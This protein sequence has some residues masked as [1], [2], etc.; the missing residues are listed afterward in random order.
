M[1]PSGQYRM[2]IVILT[3]SRAAKGSN[4]EEI[5]SWPDPAEGTGSYYAAIEQFAANE[6]IAQGQ[7]HATGSKRLRIRGRRIAVTTNDR[8]RDKVTDEV[9]NVTGVV[10]DGM[11]TVIDVSR[12]NSQETDQ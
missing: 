8:I 10:R 3:E 1:V 2:R 11:E 4:G 12:V 6:V 9:F 5:P 7:N